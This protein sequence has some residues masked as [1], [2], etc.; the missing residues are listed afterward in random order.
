[1]SPYQPPDI[2]APRLIP[3]EWMPEGEWMARHR[4]NVELAERTRPEVVLYGA[5]IIEAWLLDASLQT[6]CA[7]HALGLGIG[8]DMTQQLL[9]RLQ[10]GETGQ[11]DPRVV[12]TLIGNNNMGHQDDGPDAICRG[13]L[14]VQAEL[15]RRFPRARHVYLSIWPCRERP[16]DPLRLRA[17]AT[18][19]LIEIHAGPAGFEVLD[20]GHALVD[21]RGFVPAALAE[22]FL[23]P[24]PTG[25]ARLADALRPH[26]DL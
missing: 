23:H 13:V 5:S 4:R 26:L 3:T 22:D 11:L 6:V 14:A 16:D 24:T 10:N 18:N 20:I 19:A 17:D 8:G 15:R 12:L 21:A 7:G 1:M 2:A 25:Y 9:W